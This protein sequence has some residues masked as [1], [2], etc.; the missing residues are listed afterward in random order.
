MQSFINEKLT[1][2]IFTGHSLGAG[3]AVLLGSL[4]RPRYPHLRVYAFATPGKSPTTDL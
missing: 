1:I 4:L 2:D 3:L